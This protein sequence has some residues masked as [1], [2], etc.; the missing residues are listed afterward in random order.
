MVYHC[1]ALYC[2]A[3]TRKVNRHEDYP[4]MRGVTFHKFPSDKLKQSRWDKVIRNSRLCSRH[5]EHLDSDGKPVGDPTLWHWN[6][7]GMSVTAR[8]ALAVYKRDAAAAREMGSNAFTEW[9]PGDILS[10]HS[11][12]I[13]GFLPFLLKSSSIS[14]EEN[15][16]TLECVRFFTPE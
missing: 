9:A 15:C 14:R 6:N 16:A 8:P 3:S 11:G 13:C 1:A 2:T 10:P 4:W 7:Y 5:F 12:G